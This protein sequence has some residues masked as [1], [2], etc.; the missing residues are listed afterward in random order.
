MRLIL[1]EIEGDRPHGW[2]RAF[3]SFGDMAEW[4]NECMAGWLVSEIALSLH[5]GTCI[6]GDSMNQCVYFA[7]ALR[8]S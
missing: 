8:K 1:D 3:G 4:M 6:C 2:M 7:T 5:M